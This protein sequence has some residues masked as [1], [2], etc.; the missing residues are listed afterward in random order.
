M[1]IFK[2]IIA[3][4]GHVAGSVWKAISH[5]FAADILP[6]AIAV[7]EDINNAV[8]S[9]TAQE[10]VS[11]LIAINPQVGNVAQDILNEA[12]TLAPK[13]LAT[14]LGLQTLESGAT[15]EQAVAWAQSVVNA[16]ASATQIQQTKVW[17]T[18]ATQ[19]AVLFDNGRTQNK[20]WADWIGTVDQAFKAI[21]QAVAN[22]KGGTLNGSGSGTTTQS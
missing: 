14:E 4:I 22:Q 8:K 17:S 5:L 12:Q 15:A 18:L 20:T 21:Q 2:K 19:L 6:A 7:T 13:I 3:D 11:V 10:V 9:G 16:Y 1:S